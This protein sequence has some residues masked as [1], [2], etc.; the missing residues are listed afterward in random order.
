M[1]LPRV[2]KSWREITRRRADHHG[3]RHRIARLG[4]IDHQIKR[5]K[6]EQ[7]G[8]RKRGRF[9]H[10]EQ[11]KQ[12][13]TEDG[14]VGQR[15]QRYHLK[16]RGKQRQRKPGPRRVLHDIFVDL[17]DPGVAGNSLWVVPFR[18]ADRLQFIDE[19]M[20]IVARDVG[21]EPAGSEFLE[22]MRLPE[23]ADVVIHPAALVPARYRPDVAR[24]HQQKAEAANKPEGFQLTHVEPAN[25]LIS[26]LLVAAIAG[27]NQA[28]GTETSTPGRDRR[29]AVEHFRDPAAG[30]GGG[31]I[32]QRTRTVEPAF[33]DLAV[34][35][36]LAILPKMPHD[37]DRDV[38]AARYQPL[39]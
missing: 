4:R 24:Q 11:S 16:V 7:C 28:A 15:V 35:L 29:L 34:R 22:Q 10:P 23:I 5:G 26:P 13:K 2:K 14:D 1:P 8:Q 39:I 12:R 20:I 38:V 30:A 9:S 25:A 33:D 18:K 27:R 19:I 32:R 36:R 17:L 6:A 37:I 3:R 31:V 21:V